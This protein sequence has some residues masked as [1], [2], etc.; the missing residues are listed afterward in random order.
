MT[1]RVSPFA[2]LTGAEKQIK[3]LEYQSVRLPYIQSGV[4]D[5]PTATTS[6]TQ[7]D[8]APSAKREQAAASA[9]SKPEPPARPSLPVPPPE[10]PRGPMPQRSDFQRTRHSQYDAVIA[11]L[12]QAEL[13]AGNYRTMS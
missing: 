7:S 4:E 5:V 10:V 13:Q 11:R 9:P 1:H 8:P 3:W 12:K 6:A 2:A